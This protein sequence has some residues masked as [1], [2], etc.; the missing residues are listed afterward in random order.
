MFLV[1]SLVLFDI[2]PLEKEFVRD[3]YIDIPRALLDGFTRAT[4]N[5][6]ILVLFYEVPYKWYPI[7]R[8]RRATAAAS[9]V[10]VY[11]AC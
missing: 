3:R 9:D 7:T 4:F 10:A 8:L 11:H 6:K 5:E 1:G 2:S